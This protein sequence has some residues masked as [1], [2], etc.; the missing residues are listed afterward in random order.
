MIAGY[1]DAGTGKGIKKGP[2]VQ[3]FDFPGALRQIPRDDEQISVDGTN[4]CRDR[5]H[6]LALCFSKVQIRKVDEGF[7]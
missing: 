4:L 1:H 5:F 7:H 6:K 3:E 2:R